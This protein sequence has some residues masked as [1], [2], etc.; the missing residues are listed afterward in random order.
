M[1]D[2]IQPVL[3]PGYG[4]RPRISN[5]GMTPMTFSEAMPPCFSVKIRCRP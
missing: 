3:V 4:P 2:E 1:F 5:I